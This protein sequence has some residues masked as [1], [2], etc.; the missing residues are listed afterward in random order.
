MQATC[1]NAKMYQHGLRNQSVTIL[2]DAAHPMDL[3]A[4]P[5]SYTADF[6]NFTLG[7]PCLTS[8]P[9][10]VK[11][12]RAAARTQEIRASSPSSPGSPQRGR[13]RMHP[14]SSDDLQ[15]RVRQLMAR[16]LLNMS[17]L[18]TEAK[19][20]VQHPLQKDMGRKRACCDEA[21]DYPLSSIQWENFLS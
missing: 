4:S 8:T 13:K 11:D 2:N 17:A 19:L 16:D 18:R 7:T 20:E 12:V 3:T 1:R 21:G 15:S 9:K 10:D 14:G 5:D 6:H